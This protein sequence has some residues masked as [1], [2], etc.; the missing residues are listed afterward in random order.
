DAT[1]IDRIKEGTCII[2][3]LNILDEGTS[4]KI[5]GVRLLGLGGDI[6]YDRLFDHG[7]AQGLVPGESGYIWSTMFQIVRL[8]QTARETFDKKETRIFCAYKSLGKEALIALL[9]S[10]VNANFCVGGHVHAPYCATFTHWTTQDAASWGSWIETTIT[11]VQDNW[12]QVQTDVE[13]CCS[14][15]VRESLESAMEVFQTVP[16]LDSMRALWGVV[17]CDLELGYA[18]ANLKNHKLGLETIST[19]MRV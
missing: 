15:T 14:A 16:S 1:V 13:K 10:H 6:V 17:L 12:A 11:Q 5:N 4:H 2:P 9:A 3:N 7:K 8:L 18:I 19:G